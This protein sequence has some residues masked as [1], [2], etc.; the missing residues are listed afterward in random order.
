MIKTQPPLDV[1]TKQT[2]FFPF[3]TFG[4]WRLRTPMIW[5]QFKRSWSIFRGNK[6]AVT[7]LLLIGIFGIMAILHPI[8]LKT[9]WPS[10]IYDP[11][12]GFDMAVVPHPVPPS[13]KHLLGTDSLG[14][15]VLSMLL[16]ATT[17]TFV[18]GLTAALCTAIVGTAIGVISGFY[19][20][21]VDAILSRISDVFLLFPA[22]IVMIIIGSRFRDIGPAQ[23]GLIYGIIAGA[24]TSSVIMRSHAMKISVMPFIEASRIAGGRSLHTLIKH[25][26]PHMLPLAG[27]QMMIAVT[28]AVVADGFISFLGMTR[29]IHNWGYIIYIA[30][31]YS[32]FLSSSQIQWNVLIPPSM[33]LSL[34][35][36]AFYLV[37]RGMKDVADPRIAERR[38]LTRRRQPLEYLKT[39]FLKTPPTERFSPSAPLPSQAAGR[40]RS[41][42]TVKATILLAKLHIVHLPSQ[43]PSSEGISGVADKPLR[44]A[45]PI[46]SQHGGLVSQIN[47]SSLV[48]SFGISPQ[49]LPSRVS[50]FLA[51]HAGLAISD[52]VAKINKSRS[53]HGLPALNLSI[54][55]AAGYVTAQERIRPGD[56][57]STYVG[58]VM[59][60]AKR[61]QQFT[62]SVNSG[63]ILIS[64]DVYHNLSGTRTHFTFGRQGLANFPWE[65]KKKMVYEVGGRTVQLFEDSHGHEI[66]RRVKPEFRSTFS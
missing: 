46:V 24:G 6:L 21:V 66:F 38:A 14:R 61:L 32:Q 2:T 52:Y 48:A 60:T 42:E 53:A 19:G 58:N 45:I 35:A 28:G 23:L 41:G 37:S 44:D 1:Q 54:G 33:S 39:R 57:T 20:G 26:L 49:R 64:E 13:T 55:I 31:T 62:F 3:S 10:G 25:V 51:T 56:G 4:R 65:K 8:L 7:G 16:A 9:V 12:T 27:L 30:F 59:K 11:I 36:L 43:N 63:G 29:N 15:D 17:P 47:N 22:P 34:F 5:S 50:A 18:L 40:L